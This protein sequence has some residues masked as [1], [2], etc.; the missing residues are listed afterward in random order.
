MHLLPKLMPM[1]P[2][3]I[4]GFD[5]EAAPTRE[6]RD[7]DMAVALVTFAVRRRVVVPSN[8]SMTA[9]PNTI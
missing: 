4:P 5:T 6:P 8:S 3:A 2:S 7:R 1:V 9:L